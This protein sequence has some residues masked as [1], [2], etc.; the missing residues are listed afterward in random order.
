[1]SSAS[2]M[3]ERPNDS[4]AV[5]APIWGTLIDEGTIEAH[6]ETDMA[7]TKTTTRAD[8]ETLSVQL[9]IR[10]TPSDSERLH[11]LAERFPVAKRNAIARAALL[12]GLEA[13]EQQPTILLGEAPKKK[14]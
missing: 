1:M 14:R 12:I 2:S 4:S 10:V 6:S 13:I 11:V 3:G 8:E 9:G 7:K 5:N